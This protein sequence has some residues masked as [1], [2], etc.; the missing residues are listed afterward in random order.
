MATEIISYA[1]PLSGP[2]GY[3]GWRVRFHF[4]AAC[5]RTHVATQENVWAS[6]DNYFTEVR[7]VC[8]SD[9][10]DRCPDAATTLVELIHP[11]RT[12]N[13]GRQGKL[14]RF[15]PTPNFGAGLGQ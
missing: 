14:Q 1:V 3:P 2:Q 6:G 7:D 10:E 13:D 5:G 15:I 12:A 4:E 9:V 11:N 8:C